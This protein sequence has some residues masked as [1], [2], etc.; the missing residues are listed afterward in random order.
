[1]EEMMQ[2]IGFFLGDGF[3]LENR[4][5][6]SNTNENLI[7]R[8]AKIMRNMG[9]EARLYRRKKTGNR[10]DEFTLVANRKMSEV[11]RHELENLKL[12]SDEQC[13][14]FLK[15]IFD[16]EG[17]VDFSS[18]RRG[19]MVKITNTDKKLI[20]LVERC[21]TKLGIKYKTSILSDKRP[22]RKKCFDVKTYGE[23]AISFV[24]I[25]R[26]YKLLSNDYLQGKVHPNYLHL[27]RC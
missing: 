4:A 21:L 17:T 1:M 26:P 25:V 18:T 7:N 3:W 11:I 5:A 6:F 19:R 20:F 10:K 24:S 2:V 8:Y 27:F 14:G 15:G 23:S 22:N 12:D 16:A 13:K 9:F